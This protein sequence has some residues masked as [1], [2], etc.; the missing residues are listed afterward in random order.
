MGEQGHDGVADEIIDETVVLGDDRPNVAEI[1]IEE[2]E[3]V[4]GTHLLG[5]G[6]EGPDVR[7][8][9][10]HLLVHLVA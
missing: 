9:Y 7:E 10:G 1:G 6:G 8:E 4:L 2:V 3:V 5:Q